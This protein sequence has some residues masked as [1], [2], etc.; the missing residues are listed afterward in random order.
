MKLRKALIERNRL[1]DA[2]LLML[3]FDSGARRNEIY[4]VKKHGLLDGNR[5]NVI[6]GKRGKEF[7]LV[8][9]DDTKELIAKY[10]EQRG[11]DDFDS[12]W[13]TGSGDKKREVSYGALYDRVVSMSDL[14]S[15]IE[16][17]TINFFPHSLR[18]S[19]VETL[20]QGQDE[21]ILDENG[22][23]KK[24]NLE[25]VQRLVNHSDPNTTQGYA[26]D[27]TDWMGY[28]QPPPLPLYKTSLLLY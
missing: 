17:E 26:K 2:V 19:R 27:H 10:L 24:F 8:Y 25:Q 13:I 7:S 20:L 5:T 16:G 12:L 11:D 3:S 18:H 4:Q 14:L 1:Q 21:R 15:E 22:K 9:L 6:I 28:K 23:P